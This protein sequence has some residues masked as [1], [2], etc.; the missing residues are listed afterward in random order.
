MQSEPLMITVKKLFHFTVKKVIILMNGKNDV[1]VGTSYA[2]KFR[3]GGF[4]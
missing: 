2:N 4:L 3:I 1:L